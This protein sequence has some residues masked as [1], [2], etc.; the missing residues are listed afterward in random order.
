MLHVLSS[1]FLSL[2]FS[3]AIFPIGL[4]VFCL[5]GQHVIKSNEKTNIPAIIIKLHLQDF[6]ISQVH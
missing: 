4:L 5:Q 3:K 1:F 6:E 2:L